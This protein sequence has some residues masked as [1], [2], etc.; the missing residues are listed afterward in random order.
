MAK[1]TQK[2]RRYTIEMTDAETGRSVMLI[3]ADPTDEDRRVVATQ[4]A[5]LAGAPDSAAACFVEMVASKPRNRRR[6]N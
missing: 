3:A 4:L 2:T 6:S 1:G 5:S